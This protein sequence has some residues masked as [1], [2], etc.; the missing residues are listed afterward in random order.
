[1]TPL[2][3]IRLSAK[4][5]SWRIDGMETFSTSAGPAPV[6]LQL[7][8]FHFVILLHDSLNLSYKYFDAQ[9]LKVLAVR[10]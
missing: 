10:K 3:P 7:L 6:T 1:M 2:W 8:H 4:K 5:F 9:T